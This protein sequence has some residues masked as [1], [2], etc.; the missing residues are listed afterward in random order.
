MEILVVVL[1]YC[2]GGVVAHSCSTLAI[3]WTIV[4]QVPLPMTLYSYITHYS[5]VVIILLILLKFKNVTCFMPLY[6]LIFINICL[7]FFCTLKTISDKGIIFFF[8][9]KHSLEKFSDESNPI[10]LIILLTTFL[11]FP[12][13]SNFLILSF[14][15]CLEKKLHLALLLW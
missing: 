12:D 7:H 8:T 3:P 15:F 1:G 14:W 6:F 13:A 5:L 9:V 10:V 11:L 4:H 2:G